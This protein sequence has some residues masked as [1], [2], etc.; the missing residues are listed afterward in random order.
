MNSTNFQ[1]QLALLPGYL[2]HHLLITI[3][4][5][6]IGILL[7][8]PLA[9]VVSRYRPAQWPTLAFASILQTFP[10]IALL[11]LMVPLLGQIGFLPAL[12]ALI[13]YSLLPILRNTVTGI[14]SVDPS[15]TE[16][17]RGMGMTDNQLLF[18]VELPLA[19]PVIIAGIR[20]ATVWV[21]GTAT[22]ST[23]VGATSL[24]NYIFSGLQTQNQVAVIFGC[25]AAAGLAIV[26]DAL[27]R[28][29]EE[30][31]SRHSR[32]LGI[33]AAVV[34]LAVLAAGLGPVISSGLTGGD[35][36]KVIVGAK[37]FTEQ[38]ILT[39]II[40]NRLRQAGY[41]AESKTNMGSTILFNALAQGTVD[42]YI[43][44]SG[45]I[46][47]NIMHRDD[48][49]GAQEVMEQMTAFLK[50]KYGVVCVGALGFENTYALAMT[51]E[52]AQQKNI[53]A[54]QDL[55]QYAPQL[56]V[57]GDYEF[58]AR[59]EWQ[60]LVDT[61]GLRF[62]DKRSMDATLMYSA[63]IRGEVD[64]ISAYSTDGRIADYDLVVLDDPKAAFPPYDAVI[65]LSP[66][67]ARDERLIAALEPL[68]G[69]ID[70]NTM[71]MANKLVDVDEKPVSTAAEWLD[72]RIR[73]K[74]L[75]GA[76]PDYGN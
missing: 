52:L 68:V 13:L 69:A 3:T 9:L 62:G 36:P 61:Y 70:D 48:S 18:R 54:I 16:A 15:L 27:I 44:Y 14:A 22:L 75:T 26:L 34:L 56:T 63:I 39:D 49:P 71:R 66:Q 10:G 32:R 55:V 20:T 60:A 19:L 28:L 21:V 4:A 73:D 37:T 43:D 65:L 53:H 25:V 74:S 17:A 35:R 5:L 64:V 58:F 76:S 59:P 67:A 23:P 50:Q 45:T 51:R 57:A 33:T 12:I 31:V 40:S 6:G 24:G 42:C 7:A 47:A 38:F 46:W 11:A 30:A 2:G 72:K 41:D 29:V 1:E 8:I